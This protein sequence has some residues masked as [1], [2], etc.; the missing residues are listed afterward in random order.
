MPTENRGIF[1]E[2]PHGRSFISPRVDRRDPSDSQI[3]RD[4]RG[5]YPQALLAAACSSGSSVGNGI[6]PAGGGISSKTACNRRSCSVSPQVTNQLA[7]APAAAACQYL[8]IPHPLGKAPRSSR[9]RESNAARSSLPEERR[10]AC[11][12]VSCTSATSSRTAS[13]LVS[14]RRTGLRVLEGRGH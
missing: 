13:R 1:A 10:E 14:S 12:R 6:Q 4:A 11:S 9:V 5:D 2:G 8:P 3:V 7:K